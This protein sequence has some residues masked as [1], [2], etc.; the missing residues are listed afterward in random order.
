[1]GDDLEDDLEA[2]EAVDT[3]MGMEM[4]LSQGMGMATEVEMGKED[5]DDEVVVME[6][7]TLAHIRRELATMGNGA[8]LELTSAMEL[9][10]MDNGASF[11]LTSAMEF[12]STMMQPS[13]ELTSAM[14]FSS[15][16]STVTTMRSIVSLVDLAGR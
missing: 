6:L 10:T 15:M 7:P 8:S 11:E 3:E 1:M 2:V 13:S 12:S 9:A 14:K 16:M 4:G 5:E